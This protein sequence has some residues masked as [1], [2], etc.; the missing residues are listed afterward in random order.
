MKPDRPRLLPDPT[1]DRDQMVAL[2]REISELASFHDHPTVDSALETCRV[3]GIDQAFANG[4]AISAAVTMVDG[5]VIEESI[6]RVPLEMPYVPGLLAFREGMAVV[7]ALRSLATDPGVLVLD[8]NGR[9]HQRGAGLATHIGVLFDVPAVGI[10]KQLLCGRL[11]DPPEEPYPMGTRIPIDDDPD[12]D[13]PTGTRIG[14]AVQTRQFDS[15]RRTINP[16]YVSPGHRIS[17]ATAADLA[18]ATTAGYK[19]PEPVRRADSLADERRIAE[20]EG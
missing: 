6:G 18:M 11:V 1:I 5:D 13:V 4:Q 19:L 7:L 17:A 16:V 2:Q 9:I 15:P 3:T 12:M 14:Y 8:G 20:L 10:A